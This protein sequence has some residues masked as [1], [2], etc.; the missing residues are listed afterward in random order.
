MLFR[1]DRVNR[2]IVFIPARKETKSFAEKVNNR[3]FPFFAVAT[4][5][6]R[7]DPLIASGAKEAAIADTILLSSLKVKTSSAYSTLELKS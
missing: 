1:A 6:L 7:R 2:R 5:K 3:V 4:L